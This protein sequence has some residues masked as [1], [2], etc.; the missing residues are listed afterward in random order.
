MLAQA[1]STTLLRCAFKS[2]GKNGATAGL[3]LIESAG[4]E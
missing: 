3:K 2:G 1:L 4:R